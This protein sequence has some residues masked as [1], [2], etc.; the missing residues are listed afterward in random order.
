M[1]V[2]KRGGVYCYEFV[3]NGERIRDTT[4]T[5]NRSA[6]RQIEAARKLA[7]AKGEAGIE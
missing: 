3:F 4:K 7:L 6:A 1:A 5:G 2:Y